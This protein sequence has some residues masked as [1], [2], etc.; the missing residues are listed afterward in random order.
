MALERYAGRPADR[1]VLYYVRPDRE[2][3]VSLGDAS[4]VV[5]SFRE[6]QERTE[7]PVRPGERC[8][9]CPFYGGMCPVGR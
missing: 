2:V 9:K 5:R 6:A 7:F 1:A 8:G 4:A 3:E